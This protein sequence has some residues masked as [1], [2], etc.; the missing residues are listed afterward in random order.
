MNRTNAVD[1]KIQAVSPELISSAMS[2]GT[3]RKM[4]PKPNNFFNI[5]S[6]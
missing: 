1:V 4:T 2:D 5:I 3:K 6:P